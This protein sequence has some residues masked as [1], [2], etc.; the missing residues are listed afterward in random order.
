MSPI[1][2]NED[3]HAASDCGGILTVRDVSIGMSRAK[4]IVLTVASLLVAKLPV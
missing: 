1:V 2:S 4:E 3:L